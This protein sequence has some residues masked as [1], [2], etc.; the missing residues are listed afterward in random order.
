[1]IKKNIAIIGGGPSALIAADILSKQNSVT[2]YEKNKAVGSKFLIAGKG[3]F[4]LTNSLAGI[5][6]ANKYTPKE[7]MKD[8]IL[9]F[10]SKALREWFS[11][12]GI[13]TFVGTSGRVFPKKGIK[14]AEVLNAIKNKLNSQN[15]K[16]EY[17]SEFVGFDENQ[18]IKMN[19]NGKL[20]T[21]LADNYIFALGGAS[22]SITGSDGKWKKYFEE[23]G[24]NTIPFESSNC[25]VNINWESHIIKNHSGKPLKNISVSVGGTVNKGE[26]VITEYGLEGNVIYPLIP[27]VRKLLKNCGKANIIIDFKPEN[28]IADLLKKVGSKSVSSKDYG[29]IFN[30]KREQ[31]ALIKSYSTKEEYLSSHSFIKKIKGLEIKVESLRDIEESISTIGG[32]DVE[33]LNQNFSLKKYPKIYCIGEMIN[34]DAPTGGFLLQGAFSMGYYSA[35]SIVLR[36]NIPY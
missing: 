7:F 1:M 13:E 19:F 32:I 21:L 8:A 14:P 35:K 18:C 12:I 24:V 2:I 25:G 11:E 20:K 30:L 9:A 29:K 23:I 5:E 16:F 34:W 4:N 6:L 17:E 10:D 27:E 15:V 28:T 26:A 3:G 33:E 22:W 31:L 36:K